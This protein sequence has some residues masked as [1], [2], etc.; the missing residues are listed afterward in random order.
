MD[1]DT[2]IGGSAGRFPATHHSAVLAARSDDPGLRAEALEAIAAAYWKPAYRY[3]RM[4]WRVPNEEAKDLVQGFFASA[5]ERGLLGR[6]DSSRGSFRSYLR[7][8]LDSYLSN[9]RKAAGR[10]KRSAGQPLLPIDPGGAQEEIAM[11]DPAGDVDPEIYFRREWIRSLF[12]LAVERLRGRLEETGRAVHFVLFERFEIGTD[13]APD[14]PSYAELAAGH[15]LTTTQVTNHLATAR[16]EFRRIL[17][18][19]LREITASEAEFR[20]E[21]RHLLGAEP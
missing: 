12:G 4:R 20:A 14:R 13:A 8:C 3:A 16:R 10:L 21:A 2:D 7:L 6:Y 11:A 15:G 19:T 17:L 18:D 1:R 9:E 5:V